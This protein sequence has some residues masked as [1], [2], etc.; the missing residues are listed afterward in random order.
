MPR[1]RDILPAVL[2]L[3]SKSIDQALSV[4][5]AHAEADEVGVLGLAMLERGRPNA[6][7]ALVAAYHRLPEDLKHKVVAQA[8]QFSTSIRRAAGGRGDQASLNALTIIEQAASTRLA[9]LV[10]SMCRHNDAHVR[11]QAGRCLVA[12]ARRA[13]SSPEPNR[14]PHLDTLSTRFL[15]EAVEQAVVLYSRHDQP[16][17][18]SAM[19]WLLP[20]PMPEALAALRSAEHAAA[21]PLAH[22]LTAEPDPASRRAL[23]S[24]IAI[25]PLADACARALTDANLGQKLGEV[26]EAGH[27]LALPAVSRA[28]ARARQPDALW[29]DA[30]QQRSMPPIARRWLPAYLAATTPDAHEQVAR[31]A[32][33]ARQTD[34]PTRLAVLRRLLTIA[35]SN[36]A[37]ARAAAGNANDAL[38]LLTRDPEPAIA[39]AALWHLIQADYAGLP[40]IL[41]DLV[42]SR[43][44]AIRRVASK[45]LAP[46]GFDR[47]W[48]AWPKLDPKRRVAAGRALIKID[49][50]FHR[51]LASRLASRD[52]DKRLRALGIIAVLNQ[53]C[54]FEEVLLDLC[55][56]HDERI[57]ASAVKALSGCTSQ[58]AKKTLDLALEHDDARIRAN[59]LE[60][61]SH[62]QA[63]ENLDKLLDMAQDQAQRPRAN[64]IKA[65]LELRAKDAL[66]SLTRM[67]GD[68]RAQHRISALWLI[69]ELGIL[70]LARL[71]AEMSLT[72]EDE[73]V[74]KRAGV[75]IQH[76]IDDLHHQADEHHTNAQ[77]DAPTEAA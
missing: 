77:E 52:P 34:T 58:A 64:A 60:A 47:Y 23:L 1:I 16:A 69:D 48:D 2:A 63:A 38:A 49:G 26:I 74:K 57:V 8:E 21:E 27:L 70:H 46:L 66:P 50:E 53:G 39:R 71:V 7:E 12:L 15:V 22:R 10:T 68:Q 32:P 18:L 13:A 61:I 44:P 3:R 35:K 75:V 28:L 5:L 51:H 65:L 43:H 67:L 45:H 33:L 41:A 17:V 36:N 9:Y 40:R 20:R 25:R 24:L 76:L 59:A 42:N 62:S 6:A 55:A 54:F 72:D 30:K 73:Q 29:P 37:D 11:E 14:Q 56:S 31:L 19:L 4:A